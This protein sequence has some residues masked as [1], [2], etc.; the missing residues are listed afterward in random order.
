MPVSDETD[1]RQP[2]L[3]ESLNPVPGKRRQAACFAAAAAARF[4]L[5]QQC[6]VPTHGQF[7]QQQAEQSD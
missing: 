5:Q 6:A 7:A 2:P 4:A 3:S 1:V